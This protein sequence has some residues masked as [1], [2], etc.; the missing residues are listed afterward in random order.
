MNDKLYNELL[1][2]CSY[3]LDEL[4]ET[5]D[6]FKARLESDRQAELEEEEDE[7]DNQGY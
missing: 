4:E 1:E 5:L 3:D 2:Y 7:D 6:Y